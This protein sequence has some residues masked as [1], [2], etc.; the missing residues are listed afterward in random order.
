MTRGRL[1]TIEGIFGSGKSVQLEKLSSYLERKGIAVVSTCDQGSIIGGRSIHDIWLSNDLSGLNADAELIEYAAAQAEQ[2]RDIIIP[3]LGA[4]Y[5]VLAERHF[6]LVTA[7]FDCAFGINW[8]VQEGLREVANAGLKPDLTFVLDVDAE[9]ALACGSDLRLRRVVKSSEFERGGVIT[10]LERV[11]I[12]FQAIISQRSSPVSFISTAQSVDATH[13]KMASEVEALI[14]P[15][16][17]DS[18]FGFIPEG[19]EDFERVIQTQIAVRQ[20]WQEFNSP[21]LLWH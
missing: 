12:A 21:H 6:D 20:E 14:S 4:G 13:L 17:K 7:Y 2:V 19:P 15:T 18:S 9:T 8:K 1:I 10:F 3:M 16:Q 5:T 11:R